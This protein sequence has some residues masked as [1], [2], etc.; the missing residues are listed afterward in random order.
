[1]P[2]SLPIRPAAGQ[3]HATMERLRHRWGWFVALGGLAVCFGLA[4]LALVISATLFAVYAIALF[5]IIAGGSEIV[6]G[7]GAKTWGRAFLW[8]VA[9]I[10]YIVAGAFALAQPGHAAVILTLMLGVSL[11]AT[12]IIRVYIGTHL[13]THARTMVILGGVVTLIVGLFVVMG[14]PNKSIVI[15]GTL[16]GVDLLFTGVTWIGFG[17]RLR[18]HA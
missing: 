5:M 6:V 2:S 9:G 12:G 7:I 10:F 4:A 18:S 17:L 15:L 1:M 14:W 13:H 16:L 11:V 3:S 8:V